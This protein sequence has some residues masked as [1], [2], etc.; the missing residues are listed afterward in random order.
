MWWFS[1]LRPC[2]LSSSDTVCHSGT[3]A[4]CQ[5]SYSDRGQST[6]HETNVSICAKKRKRKK[7][8]DS[9]VICVKCK[10]M[11]AKSKSS[12]A[13]HQCQSSKFQVLK[14]A[15]R[16]RFESSHVARVSHLWLAPTVTPSHHTDNRQISEGRLTADLAQLICFKSALFFWVWWRLTRKHAAQTDEVITARELDEV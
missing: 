4:I 15:T 7:S 16:D 1:E 10:V 2:C 12:R 14:F 8:Q 9:R 5:A 6:K 11:N 3:P 13:F